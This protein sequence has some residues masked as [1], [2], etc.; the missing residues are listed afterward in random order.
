[1]Y[2]SEEEERVKRV[3]VFEPSDFSISGV[4]NAINKALYFDHGINIQETG[5]PNEFKMESDQGKSLILPS[6]VSFLF[7]IPIDREIKNGDV[8]GVCNLDNHYDNTS[9]TMSV[10]CDIITPQLYGSSMKTVL[11]VIE[12][13][14]H[15]K[16]MFKDFNPIQYVPLAAKSFETVNIS[17]RETSGEPVF[18]NRL[19]ETIVVLHLCPK[20]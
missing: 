15:F 5:I 11:R 19:S 8:I 6:A 20:Y 12:K 18:L 9:D 17:I 4:K 16:K 10:M 1:V 2:P 7:G 13:A 3:K 14:R